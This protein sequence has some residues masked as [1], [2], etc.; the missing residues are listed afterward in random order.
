LTVAYVVESGLRIAGHRAA[1]ELGA[2]PP[3]APPFALKYSR[4]SAPG[5]FQQHAGEAAAVA[6]SVVQH[7]V[8]SL[9]R[10]STST[11]TQYV[12]QRRPSG[13]VAQTL[14]CTA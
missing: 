8:A 2:S 6:A 1:T 9:S 10:S 5:S 7:V 13:S 4:D 14:F 3:T 12:S 11:I